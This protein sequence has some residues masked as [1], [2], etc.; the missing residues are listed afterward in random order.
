MKL[1]LST[2]WIV[3]AIAAALFGY[4]ANNG[5]AAFANT[6]A[7]ANSFRVELLNGI[8]AFGTTVVRGATTKDTF[9]AA[10][11][12]ASA[13]MDS[14]AT[15]Y[16]ATNEVSGT[17]YSAGG[18]TVTNANAPSNTGSTAFWTPSAALAWTTVTLATAFDAVLI[19]NSTQSNKAVAVYTFG[20]QTVTAG[21]FSLTMPTND[22]STGLLRIA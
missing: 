11:Y 21:N 8:H 15:A 3:A 6:Q 1:S 2:R 18:V 22:A 13:T 16:T 17:N 10:L 7:V 20:S 9:K 4:M 12:L 14:S 19:Y 5:L